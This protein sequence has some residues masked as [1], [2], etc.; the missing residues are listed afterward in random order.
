MRNLYALHSHKF[1]RNSFIHLN[2]FI[3]FSGSKYK[4]VGD[5]GHYFYY[6]NF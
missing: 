2:I 1:L 5:K 3:Y 6:N 4:I